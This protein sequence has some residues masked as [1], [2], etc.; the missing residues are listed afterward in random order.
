MIVIE[1]YIDLLCAKKT[2]INQIIKILASET[3]H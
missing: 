2:Y 3:V 1:M